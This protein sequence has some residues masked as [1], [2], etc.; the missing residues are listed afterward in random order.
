MEAKHQSKYELIIDQ[1]EKK[2]KNVDIIFIK[3][4]DQAWSRICKSLGPIYRKNV[5]DF[6][7]SNSFENTDPSFAF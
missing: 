3:S 1:S 4:C 6:Y 7:S 5:C 2:N